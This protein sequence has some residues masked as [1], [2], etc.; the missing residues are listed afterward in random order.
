MAQLADDEKVPTS[1]G[2]KANELWPGNLLPIEAKIM[3]KVL[4]SGL[5]KVISGYYINKN[6]KVA[7]VK[8]NCMKEANEVSH[9]YASNYLISIQSG[10]MDVCESY[11]YT[12]N[13]KLYPIWRIGISSFAVILHKPLSWKF[14]G[15][16]GHAKQ[17]S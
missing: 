2:H 3:V 7:I 12:K 6:L 4:E 16:F 10:I 13:M 9:N 5:N 8:F 14:G 11:L 17:L 1:L 15:S